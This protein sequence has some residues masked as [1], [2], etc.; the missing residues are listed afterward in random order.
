VKDQKHKMGVLK[1]IYGMA[2]KKMAEKPKKEKKEEDDDD[3]D[4]PL[5]AKSKG[6]AV[7]IRI[8]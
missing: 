2:V 6:P 4:L 8:G 3:D 1:E 5:A 7:T